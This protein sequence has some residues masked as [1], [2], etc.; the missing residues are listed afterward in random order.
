MGIFWSL[1]RRSSSASLMAL[2]VPR[3]INLALFLFVILEWITDYELEFDEVA[4][5]LFNVKVDELMQGADIAQFE[6][7]E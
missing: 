4:E 1:Q 3:P 7:K 5:Q 6:M 2:L